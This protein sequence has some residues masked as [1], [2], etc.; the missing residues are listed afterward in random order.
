MV[1]DK[2]RQALSGDT[3]VRLIFHGPPPELMS[4]VF[5]LLERSSTV[6]PVLFLLPR[7]L[8]GEANPQPGASGRCDDTHLLNL[9]NSPSQPTFLALVPPGQH[10]MRSVTST[11]DEFGVAALNNGGNIPFE[12][13]WADEFVQ[14]LVREGIARCGLHDQA[15]REE[16]RVLVGRAAAAADELDPER[17]QR[18]NAWRVLSR[19]FEAAA[20]SI[21]LAP[22]TKISLAC[23]VPPQGDGSLAA[24]EQLAV[25]EKVADSMSDGF[26][27]G[28]RRAKDN[29]AQEDQDHLDTF[30]VHLRS[31]CDLPTAFERATASYYAPGNGLELPVATD[32]WLALT[33]EKWNELLAEDA[34]AH[35]DIRISCTNPLVHHGKGMP[36][37]VESAVKLAFEAV[38][39]RA[40]GTVL[41][42]ER[43]P[44]GNEIGQVLIDDGSATLVDEALPQH[45]SP[46]RYAASA[47]GF[48]PG[49]I[50]VISLSSWQPGIFVACR[51]ARKLTP[52]AQAAARAEGRANVRDQ[53]G[54]AWWRTVRNTGVY[55]TR[56]PLGAIRGR[57]GRR[58]AGARGRSRQV[59][60]STREARPSPGGGGGR[61]ELPT[62]HR[63]RARISRRIRLPGNLPPFH[64]RRGRGRTGLQERVRAVDPRQSP[65][66]RPVGRKAGGAAQPKRPFRKPPGL[67]ACRGC[68]RQVIPSDRAR[69]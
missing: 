2:L 14:D 63:L 56:H 53:H 38:G 45:K 7:L 35:G 26:G 25:L 5:E 9:R 66:R 30:L 10:S 6:V 67:D 13:W 50:K 64:F 69:R 20:S 65:P 60:S 39:P 21:D 23:G 32:W 37:V 33:V 31:V 55:G 68:R 19:L 41:S 1:N 11:T 51:L 22:G 29:A 61:D 54:R 4:S 42:I 59:A 40:T 8:P 57:N 36:I 44:K 49:S 52:P 27:A 18:A 3:E 17:T 16:A 15:Q 43:G 46:M 48:K 62:R 12:D 28:I 24:R 47:L 58:R 34:G